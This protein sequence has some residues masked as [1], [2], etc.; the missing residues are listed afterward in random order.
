M[1]ALNLGTKFDH[2]FDFHSK[3][4]MQHNSFCVIHSLSQVKIEVLIVVELVIIL[5]IIQPDQM[6]DIFLRYSNC[7]FKRFM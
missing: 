4:S 3:L 6:T 1:D 5:R 7:S 2:S